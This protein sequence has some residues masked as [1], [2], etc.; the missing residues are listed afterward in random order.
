MWGLKNGYALM[1]GGSDEDV[2]KVQPIFDA[3]KPEG[4][5]GSVHAGKVGATTSRRWS[6]T[7]SSTP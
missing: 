3:L 6:T 1:Y 4:D 5:F 7:A 2:A